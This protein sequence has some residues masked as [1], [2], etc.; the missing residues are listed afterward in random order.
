MRVPAV[1]C[2]DQDGWPARAACRH[3]DP[4]LFF[5]VTMRGPPLGQLARARQVC[6]SCPVRAECLQ[7]ALETGEDFGV[8]GGA[9]E[10]ERRL[11]RRRLLPGAAPR[12]P[13]NR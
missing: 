2:A 1:S 10:Q 3:G 7:Y 6:G 11:M 8:W 12:R 13:D 4:E 5:P 9:S